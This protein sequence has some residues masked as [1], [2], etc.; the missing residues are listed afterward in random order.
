MA[1]DSIPKRIMNHET[2]GKRKIGRPRT[3]WLDQVGRDAVRLGASSW[4]T[5]ARD[6]DQG[7]DWAVEPKMYVCMKMETI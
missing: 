2:V 3:R 5:M 1:E 4:W 7:S 6:R